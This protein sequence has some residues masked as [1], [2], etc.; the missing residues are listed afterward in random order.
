MNLLLLL[1]TT[2]E[3]LYTGD[4]SKNKLNST[5][6]MVIGNAFRGLARHDRFEK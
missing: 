1:F 6:S 2:L 4:F 5:R 3:D